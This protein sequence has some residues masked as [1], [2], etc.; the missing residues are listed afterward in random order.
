MPA[1][2]HAFVT[3][4]KS[5]A[6]LAISVV[7]AKE[8]ALPAAER[9]PGHWHRNRDVDTHH[10]DLDLV[11]ELLCDRTVVSIAGHAIAKTLCI[12]QLDGALEIR[13]PHDAKHRA[14]NLLAIN[15]HLRSD[16]IEE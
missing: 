1:L 16:V 6:F 11:R 2:H 7:A 5:H 8:G 12:D 15:P 10:A 4:V 3:R 13:H 14:E 9:V